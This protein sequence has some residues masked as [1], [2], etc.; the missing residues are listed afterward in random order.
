MSA[1]LLIKV[2]NLCC[3]VVK[4]RN[5][6]DKLKFDALD[7]T[8]TEWTFSFKALKYLNFGDVRSAIREGLEC[9]LYA[10]QWRF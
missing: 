7:Q 10:F 3:Q 8:G 4:E 9:R 1:F 5:L 6:L 2:Y